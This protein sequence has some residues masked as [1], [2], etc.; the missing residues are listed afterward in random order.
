MQGQITENVL[1]KKKKKMPEIEVHMLNY[2]TIST[3]YICGTLDITE[4]AEWLRDSPNYNLLSL[5]SSGQSE[6]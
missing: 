3:K 2:F 4:D 1:C 5:C 6:N